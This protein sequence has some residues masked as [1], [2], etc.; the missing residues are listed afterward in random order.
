MNLNQVTALYARVLRQ[1]LPEGGY[2]TAQGTVLS[3]DIYAHAKAFA[4]IDLDAH[5][6]LTALADMPPEML[7]EYEQ[8]YGLPLKCQT[9]VSMSYAERIALLNEMRSK[10]NTLNYAYVEWILSLF[11][12]EL[13]AIDKYVPMQCTA[14]CNRPVET[15]RSRFKVKLRLANP[16]N[17]DM[18]C[19]I[20]NYLPSYLRVEWYGV[21]SDF[22]SWIVN[23]T[24]TVNSSG[25]AHYTGYKTNGYDYYDSYA[26][27][28]LVTAIAASLHDAD[29][30]TWQGVT[31]AINAFG[32]TTWT[33]DNVNSRISYTASANGEPEYYWQYTNDGP[34]YDNPN[35]ACIYVFNSG[36]SA[37]YHEYTGYEF[38]RDTHL[39]Q[40][41]CR[42]RDTRYGVYQTFVNLN[43]KRNPAYIAGTFY[44]S[45][46]EIAEQIV[47]HLSSSDMAIQLHAENYA[48]MIA[49][50]I[51]ETNPADQYVKL[52]D[53]ISQFEANK[54]QRT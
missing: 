8:Q 44:K 48:E 46:A 30:R 5:R 3:K 40:V 17:A 11:G 20:E 9:N 14:P 33:W 19:I 13:L 27:L 34:I 50:S 52:T 49:N 23:S 35:D 24:V 39:R 10:R 26:N 37:E 53:L 2:D 7:S 28:N 16:V 12:V 51:F 42:R 15:E 38:T 47:L 22:G 41:A 54:I 29:V 36:I 31:D 1:L 18:Q 4:Q 21:S 32:V 43:E 25:V 6:L 45:Y